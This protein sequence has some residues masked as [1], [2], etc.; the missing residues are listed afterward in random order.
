MRVIVILRQVFDPA[1]I[2]VSSRG[3][4]AT[5][6]GVLVIGAAS[7][8]ALEEALKLKDSTPAEVVALALSDQATRDALFEALAMGADRAV[9]LSDAALDGSD[10]SGVAHALA[11]AVSVLGPADLVLAG[12]RSPEDEAGPIGPAVAENLG[13]PQ[14]SAALSLSVSGGRAVALQALEDGERRISAPL[15]AV[16]TVSA[17]TNVPRLPTVASIMGVYASGA[18]E[19]WSAAEIG[20]DSSRMGRAGA[21]TTVRR[22]FAPEPWPKND[23]LSGS[24]QQA[25]SALVARLRRRGIL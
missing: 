19:T 1:T 10:D 3:D 13:W 17:R 7:L 5:Q 6:E 14:I 18:V 2:R 8:C 22:R 21:L 25:A 15:P 16:I 23:I 4:L 11:R 24:P 12:D 9:L 20:A